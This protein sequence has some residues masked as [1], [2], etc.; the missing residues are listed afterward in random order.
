V[1]FTWTFTASVKGLSS[2]VR[3]N[4]CSDSTQ[5]SITQIPICALCVNGGGSQVGLVG[6]TASLPPTQ[7]S[8]SDPV[9]LSEKTERKKVVLQILPLFHSSNTSTHENRE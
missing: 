5:L 7:D 8:G 1:K 3:G 4:T 6:V 2:N 9:S